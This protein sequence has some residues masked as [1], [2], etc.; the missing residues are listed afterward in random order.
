MKEIKL[1]KGYVALVDDEDY[2]KVSEYPWH[3]LETPDKT[4]YA[5]RN[6]RE[7]GKCKSWYMHRFILEVTDPEVEVDHKDRNGLNNQ[8]HNIRVT[9]GNQNHFNM[10]L[11]KDNKSGFRGVHWSVAA[12]K[13]VARITINHKI[14][15]LGVFVDPIEAACAYDMAAVKYH[16]D[17]ASTNFAE[18][19]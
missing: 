4:V 14:I 17:F 6:F 10:G 1:S 16:G 3:A 9:E 13:W 12:D 18:P 2:K 15:H 5:V 8:R 11:R 19:S 7:E